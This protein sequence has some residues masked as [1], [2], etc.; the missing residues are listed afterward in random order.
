MKTK[1]IASLV[2]YSG[3]LFQIAMASPFE[4]GSPVIRRLEKARD[5]LSKETSYC[6]SIVQINHA[7]R[8][9]L[10]NESSEVPRTL[11]N[12]RIAGFQVEVKQMTPS[13]RAEM[14]SKN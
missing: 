4:E 9:N 5:E 2:L 6:S 7:M 14:K 10:K 1:I 13:L 8:P 11:Q 3:F 12:C